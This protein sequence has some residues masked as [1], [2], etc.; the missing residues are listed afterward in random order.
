MYLPGSLD[1]GINAARVVF[2]NCYFDETLCEDGLNVL[3][4]YCWKVD[5]RGQL[6]KLVNSDGADAFKYFAVSTKVRRVGGAAA[7]REGG[8]A[9][10][11]APALLEFLV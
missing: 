6:T 9:A 2:P 5:E 8:L 11:L 1:D 7:P 4:R 3:R 10:R